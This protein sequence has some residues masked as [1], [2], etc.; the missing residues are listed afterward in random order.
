MENTP[1]TKMSGPPACPPSNR[2]A[3]WD[4][5]I[6]RLVR[7]LSAFAPEHFERVGNGYYLVSDEALEIPE[8]LVKTLTKIQIQNYDAKTKSRLRP[9][10]GSQPPRLL[11]SRRY[12]DAL[13]GVL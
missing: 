12:G 8:D 4:L 6:S 9:P 1:L 11:W 10:A 2:V 13:A 5:H 7:W 3:G